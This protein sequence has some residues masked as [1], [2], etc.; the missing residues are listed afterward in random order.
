MRNEAAFIEQNL[1]ALRAQ[2]YPLDRLEIVIADGRS[3]DATRDIVRAVA[4]RWQRDGAARHCPVR[5]VDNPDR[6]MPAGVNAAIRAATGDCTLLL[7]GHARLPSTYIREC[8][9]VLVESGV[10]GVSGVVES[11]SR[12]VV[13]EA[14]ADAMSS[15]FGIGNS[16]FRIAKSGGPPVPAETLPFPLFRRSVYERIGLYNP[17][18]VRHQDYEFN[19]RLRQAGGRML[20]L[21]GLRATYHVRSSLRVLWRQ[22]WQYG[23]YKGRFL[24]RFPRS[25]RLRHLIPPL[26]SLAV[27]VAAALALVHPAGRWLLAALLLPYAFFV[28]A[29]V[30]SFLGARKWRTALLTPA[31]FFCLHFGYGLGIWFGLAQPRVPPAPALEP[32]RR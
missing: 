25:L 24:R 2:D 5:L 14:I 18:M 20:L 9:E 21:P 17:H 3:E 26:F 27:A 22:Y 1:E 19:Y 28:G 31:V 32:E 15:P 4:E 7:G 6:V 12:G 30:A 29:A 11:V 8:V 10:D 13:G 16:D 23:I